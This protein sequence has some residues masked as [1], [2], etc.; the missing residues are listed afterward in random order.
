[1]PRKDPA[2]APKN[3]PTDPKKEEKTSVPAKKNATKNG[4]VSKKNF[5]PNSFSNDPEIVKAGR[6]HKITDEIIEAV[7]SAIRAGAY[8]ETAAAFAGISKDT[9]Y[10][11]LKAGARGEGKKLVQFSDAVKRATAESEL[12]DLAVVNRAASTSWQA[13]AWKLERKYPDRWGRRDRVEIGAAGSGEA[14]PIQ[15]SYTGVATAITG[16]GTATDLAVPDPEP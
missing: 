11:W 8:I 15:I 9:F 12:R 3:D 1:M 14:K 13:A 5:M 16:S 7:V 4:R 6:P 10:R 2:A